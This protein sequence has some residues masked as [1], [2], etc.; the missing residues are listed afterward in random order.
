MNFLPIKLNPGGVIPV[1]FAQ[2]VLTAPVTIMG[3]INPNSAAY[4]KVQHI[5][6][7]TETINGWPLVVGGFAP[8]GLFVSNFYDDFSFVGVAALRKF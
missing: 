6:S 5:F 2:A 4:T 1:I 7:L 8:G 3:F